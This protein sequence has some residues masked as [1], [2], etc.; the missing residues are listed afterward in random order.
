MPAQ[1]GPEDVVGRAEREKSRASRGHAERQRPRRIEIE[2]KNRPGTEELIGGRLAGDV[3]HWQLERGD[4]QAAGL[5]EANE[6]STRLDERLQR[7]DAIL[8]E[9][10]DVLR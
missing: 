3:A 6:R 9:T 2:A 8:S 7:V 1:L 5:I 4:G 10:A